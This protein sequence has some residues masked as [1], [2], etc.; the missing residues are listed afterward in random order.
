MSAT[1]W[2]RAVRFVQNDSTGLS[3][4]WPG[5]KARGPHRRTA[6]DPSLPGGSRRSRRTRLVEGWRRVG[7]SQD[8]ARRK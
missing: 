6:F 5:S 1:R 4:C 3:M 8:R 2:A 7:A